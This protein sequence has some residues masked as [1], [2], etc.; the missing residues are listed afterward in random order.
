MRE[1]TRQERRCYIII[2][3]I[4]FLRRSYPKLKLCK[5]IRKKRRRQSLDFVSGSVHRLGWRVFP[6]FIGNFST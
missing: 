5:E 6:T 2:I 3:I 4:K 1:M